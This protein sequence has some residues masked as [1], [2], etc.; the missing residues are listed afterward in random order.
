M[1]LQN[2][3]SN[4]IPKSSDRLALAAVVAFVGTV[5]LTTQ[6]GGMLGALGA[7]AIYGSVTAG[8]AAISAGTAGLAMGSLG[9]VATAAGGLHGLGVIGGGAAAAVAVASGVGIA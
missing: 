1:S 4:T 7:A 6:L 3:V 2:T 5:L 8:S 9:G